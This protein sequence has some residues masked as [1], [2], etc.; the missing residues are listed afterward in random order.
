MNKRIPRAKDFS[1]KALVVAEI[2]SLERSILIAAV[3][4]MKIRRVIVFVT[5]RN[6]SVV[7]TGPICPLK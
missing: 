6:T 3:E 5:S 4:Q 2:K 7:I 1:E